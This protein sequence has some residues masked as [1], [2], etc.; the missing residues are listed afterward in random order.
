VAVSGD[1]LVACTHSLG[2]NP[3]A[4][5]FQRNEGAAGAWAEVAALLPEGGFDDPGG[6]AIDGD[7]AAVGDQG[8]DSQTGAVYLFARDAGGPNHW[9]QIAKLVPAGARPSSY[10]G[11]SVAVDG[12][13][14]VAGA[15]GDGVL[16]EQAGA[17]W[18]FQRTGADPARVGSRRPACRPPTGI[19]STTSAAPWTSMATRSWWAPP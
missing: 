10:F 2:A 9:G 5:I 3:G 18:V 14:L 1:T 12:D 8:D 13:T 15:L 11:G 16:G 19:A 7:V 17:A 6:V 4:W